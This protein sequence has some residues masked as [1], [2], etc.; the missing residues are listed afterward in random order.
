MN[1]FLQH[2]K[3]EDYLWQTSLAQNDRNNVVGKKKKSEICGSMFTWINEF[4]V[5]FFRS[6]GQSPGRGIVLLP[7]SALV[8]GSVSMLAK[9]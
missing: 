4:V 2:Y 1:K 9:C 5:F 6:F 7:A 3:N 8:A